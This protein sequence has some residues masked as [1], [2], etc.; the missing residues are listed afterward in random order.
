MNATF[1]F[2]RQEMINFGRCTIVSDDIETFVI[3]IENEVLALHRS[4]KDR[5]R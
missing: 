2:V 5:R 3:H 1:S 4:Q